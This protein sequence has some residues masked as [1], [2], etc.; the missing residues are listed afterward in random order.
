LSRPETIEETAELVTAVGGTGIAVRVDHTLESDVAA[1]VARVAREQDARLDLLV[2][3]VW[4]GDSAGD[5]LWK[6]LHET[7]VE[8]GWQLMRQAVFSHMLT[9]RLAAPL[10]IA[11]RSGLI[12]EITDG[13]TLSYRG[14]VFYDMIKTSIMRLAFAMSVELRPHRVA[15][16][17]VSPGFLRSE[18]ML[19]HFG[20]TEATWRDGAKKDKHFIA[21]ETP[22]LVGRAVAALAAD[23]RVLARSGETMASWDL[24]RQY[25]LADVD[26]RRPDWLAHFRARIPRNHPARDWMRQALDWEKVMATKTRRFLG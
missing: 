5:W 23:R 20:V 2:N 3:D 11:R 9:T 4:G 24:A 15:A 7:D 6:P 1:L 25:K 18:A 22:R 17:A 16:I 8:A 19:E 14:A 10:M 13:D 26:G 21:S 12:V